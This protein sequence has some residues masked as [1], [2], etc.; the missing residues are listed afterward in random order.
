MRRHVSEAPD[1]LKRFIWEIERGE[2]RPIVGRE[3]ILDVLHGRHAWLGDIIERGLAGLKFER[4][5]CVTLPTKMLDVVKSLDKE[6]LEPRLP[7]SF[8]L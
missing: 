5:T 8:F 4:I 6:T 1:Y 3:Y 2:S 7:P